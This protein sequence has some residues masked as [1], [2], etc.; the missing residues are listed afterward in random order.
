MSVLQQPFLLNDKDIMSGSYPRSGVALAY[1]TLSKKQGKYDE[2]IGLPNLQ[3]RESFSHCLNILAIGGSVTFGSPG[4]SGK[5][6]DAPQNRKKEGGGW[7]F[8]L[9]AWPTVLEERL[10]DNYPCSKG[11]ESKHVVANMGATGCSAKCFIDRWPENIQSFLSSTWDAIIIEPTSN[12]RVN[13]MNH[14]QALISSFARVQ[15]SAGLKY[16]NIILL[17]ASFRLESENITERPLEYEQLPGIEEAVSSLASELHIPYVSFPRYIFSNRMYNVTNHRMRCLLAEC[18]YWLDHVHLTKAAHRMVADFAFQ[19]ITRN[20]TTAGLLLNNKGIEVQVSFDDLIMN[21]SEPVN[22]LLPAVPAYW[23]SFRTESLPDSDICLDGFEPHN[24]RGRLS[25]LY[26]YTRQLKDNQGKKA[27]FVLELPSCNNNDFNIRI[28]Y[29]HSYTT[30]GTLELVS[31][32]DTEDK[33]SCDQ[34]RKQEIMRPQFQTVGSFN[35]SNPNLI[36]VS[37]SSEFRVSGASTHIQ[38][39]VYGG[40]FHLLSLAVYCTS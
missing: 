18:T 7:L 1:N 17:S 5:H 26:N 24:S 14:L 11:G 15:Q 21:I 25:A 3:Q 35:A 30:D 33:R 2:M 12:S 8:S 13:E 31:W 37:N 22:N 36:S 20:S 16:P 28:E 40:D 34:Y 6:P 23:L 39:S 10:N 32:Y 38:G 27:S 29:L 4:W 9:D 19:A